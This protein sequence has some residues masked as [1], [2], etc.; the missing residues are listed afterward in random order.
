MEKEKTKMSPLG[1]ELYWGYQYEP[2]LLICRDIDI[3]IYASVCAYLHTCICIFP[4]YVIE[5]YWKL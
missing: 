2:W 3:I 4:S 1:L 5:R